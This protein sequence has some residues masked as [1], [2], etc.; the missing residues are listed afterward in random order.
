MGKDS[1]QQLQ[2]EQRVG[3]KQMA[4]RIR[5]F[6]MVAR[7]RNAACNWHM[8]YSLTAGVIS[9]RDKYFFFIENPSGECN[10]AYVPFQCIRQGGEGKS[11][12]GCLSSAQI[13][14]EK[15][16]NVERAVRS[17]LLIKKMKKASGKKRFKKLDYCTRVVLPSVK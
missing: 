12:Y 7:S 10:Y 1:V 9:T 13:V 11:R 2:I 14:I 3:S 6:R 4:P 17:T 8:S 5:E 16:C 15:G